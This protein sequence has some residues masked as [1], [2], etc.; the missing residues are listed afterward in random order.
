MVQNENPMQSRD[1]YGR[2]SWLNTAERPFDCSQPSLT[3]PRLTQITPHRPHPHELALTVE[4][5]LRSCAR[6]PVKEFAVIA[7]L[8]DGREVN[9]T[10]QT[11]KNFQPRIFSPHLK[12]DFHKS[13]QRAALDASFSNSTSYNPESGYSE[14]SM[15]SAP[16]MRRLAGNDSGSG[17]RRR[18][19]QLRQ[20]S[21]DSDDD[22]STGSKKT[23][24][25]H[26]QYDDSSEDTPSP[27][28]ERKTMLL[29]IGDEEEVTKFYSCRFKDMQQ[30]SCKVMGKAFVKLVEPRKQTHYPY[31]KGADK[32]PPWWPATSGDLSVRHR[33]PDHL[34]KPERIRLLVH[35]LRMIIEPYH[36]QC[37]AVQ[38]L[39]LNVKKLEEVTMEAMSN[40]FTEK[41]HPENSAKKPF[42]KEI[43]KVARMEEQY[44]NGERDPDTYISVMYGDRNGAEISD[45]EPDEGMKLEDDDLQSQEIEASSMIMTPNSSVSPSIIHV[46]QAQQ[47]PPSNHQR[48]HDNVY[49]PARHVSVRYNPQHEDHIQNS[50]Y[51]NNATGYV[52]RVNFNDPSSSS[53]QDQ[54]QRSMSTSMSTSMSPAQYQNSQQA[55]VSW[56]PSFFSNPSPASSFYTTSP[57]S[58]SFTSN[59]PQPFS[60]N[61]YQLPP[62]NSQSVLPSHS[63]GHS[64][65][66]SY[67][68]LPH[69]SQYDTTPQLG[70]QLRTGSLGHP[71]QLPTHQHHGG[72]DFLDSNNYA[73]HDSDL[74]QDPNIHQG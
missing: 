39:N 16:G 20:S 40:W 71:H 29:R 7:I 52:P 35:I 5:A 59:S 17:K 49:A 30:A 43:F 6:I 32:A 54:P 64:V 13:V 42:L 27:I 15:D 25:Y 28:V 57:Q 74:K 56:T 68:G 21:E 22:D 65:Q 67:D 3:E 63:I 19:R 38:K 4:E 12:N 46:Q 31:T 10:S 58:Q 23:K 61:T 45:D 8:D 66:S 48:E 11:L 51:I 18:H 36:K 53:L 69:R 47:G 14:F 2:E 1:C 62:P 60:S 24:R 55:S 41:D 44:K 33:E 37:S 34:L 50:S 73:H 9:Y 70:S 26:H 72:F